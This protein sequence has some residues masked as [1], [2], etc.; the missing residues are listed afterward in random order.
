MVLYPQTIAWADSL[1]FQYRQNPNGCWDWWGYSGDDYASKR[2]KQVR[3]VA[4][5][6]NTLVGSKLLDTPMR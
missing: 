3:A 2:G 5:M 1:Y 4:E 6:I